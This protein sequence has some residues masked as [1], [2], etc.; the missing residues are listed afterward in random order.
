MATNEEPVENALMA[1][2][3]VAVTLEDS[4]SSNLATLKALAESLPGKVREPLPGEAS[5]PL[6]EGASTPLSGGHQ[7]RVE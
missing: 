5:T 7:R 3:S 4:T 2:S 1:S 6:S